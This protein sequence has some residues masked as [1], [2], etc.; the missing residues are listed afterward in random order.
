MRQVAVSPGFS[1]SLMVIS[2]QS[3]FTPSPRCGER[4][5]VRGKRPKHALTP[6]LSRKREREKS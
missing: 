2:S 4:V 3:K 5:G 1:V 6:A